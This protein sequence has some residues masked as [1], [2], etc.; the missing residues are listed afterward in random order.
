MK[1]P[2]SDS[3]LWLC[4]VIVAAIL[5]A[6]AR[7]WQ[8][9]SAFEGDLRLPVPAA[10]ATIVLLALLLV[11]AVVLALLAHRQPVSPVLKDRSHC[12]LWAVGNNLF[13]VGVFLAAFL[14]LFAAPL[15]FISGM[16]MREAYQAALELARY[17]GDMIP[18][19]NNGL[20]TLATAVTSALSFV[21]LLVVGRSA[22]KG[23]K[24]GRLA[25]LLPVINSCL[26][27]MEFYRSHAANPVRWEYAILLLAIVAGILLYLD[28]A[29]LYAGVF[30]PR[31]AL[32]LAG[33]TVVLSVTALLGDWTLGSALLLTSQTAAALALLWCTPHNLRYPPELPEEEA[34]AEEKLEEDT[35]E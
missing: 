3:L 15:F 33:M 23:V 2:Y 29:G 30:A 7:L 25:I 24:K 10:P 9:H 4:A 17:R 22:Q 18:G 16:R 20:L 19:G 32:W 27:L 34:Q 5:C 6:G 1:K 28:W 26:W 21:A 13:L 14:S 11:S 31:R 35:H 8:L 12:S